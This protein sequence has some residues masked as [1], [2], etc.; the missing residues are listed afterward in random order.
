MRTQAISFLVIALS[1]GAT[2]R[3]QQAPSAPLAEKLG[4]MAQ[5]L[6]A[7]QAPVTPMYAAFGANRAPESFLVSL[8]A[9]ACYTLVGAG[10]FGVRDVDMFLFDP[11]GKRVALDRRYDAYT[12]IVYCAPFAG[13]YRIELKVK[14]GEG[15]VAFQV[16]QG[17]ARAVAPE[18]PPP[19]PA[20]PPPVVAAPAR[21]NDPLAEQ[22]RSFGGGMRQFG[23]LLSGM[24]GR[25]EGQDFFINL[26]GGHCYTI[27]TVAAPSMP[28]IYTYLWSPL[29][30]RVASDR[31]S[32]NVSRLVCCATMP[33]PY[34]FQAKPAEGA[35][36]FRVGVFIQ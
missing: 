36:E 31:S 3:A 6:A 15:E 2:A 9:G 7:G 29:N 23:P 32:S 34:H 16:F 30:K 18:T 24:G 14:R 27:I 8:A 1:T 33:G 19:P 5:S 26:E 4:A 28:R 12:H 11:A 22:V 10:G 35:G 20:M 13:S 25:G 21:A 17:N